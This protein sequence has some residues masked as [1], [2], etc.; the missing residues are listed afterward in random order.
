MALALLA[1][2]AFPAL[3]AETTVVTSLLPPFTSP[4]TPE[5]PGFYVEV[6][7]AAFEKAGLP[8]SV[9]FQPWA[10]AQANTLATPGL[11]ILGLAHTPERDKKFKF[12]AEIIAHNIC[13]ISMKP[14]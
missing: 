9:E 10:R 7:K 13:F 1:A 8:F 4:E 11:F 6:A 12:A 2:V 3:S 5:R 14:N